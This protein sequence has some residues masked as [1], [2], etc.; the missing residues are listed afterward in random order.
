MDLL[1]TVIKL[2]F[3]GLIAYAIV[4]EL[5]E[6]RN[7]LGFIK[8]VWKKFRIGMFF[9]SLLVIILVIATYAITTEFVPGANYGWSQLIFSDGGNIAVEPFVDASESRYQVVRFLPVIFLSI[10]LIA[11]PFIAKWEEEVFREGYIEWKEILWQSTKFGFAHCIY[12]GVPIGAG[13]ALII[14][15]L[16]FGYHYKKSFEKNLDNLGY[17]EA[18]ENAVFHSTV[19]HTMYNSILITLLLVGSI[20]AL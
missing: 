6:K 15:G 18:E 7:E 3:G 9:Q 12:A 14:A 8:D 5:V 19:V 10:F 4:S 17:W 2:V 16:F 13:I 20:F 11:L 1:I